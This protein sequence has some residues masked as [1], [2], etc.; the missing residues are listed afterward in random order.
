MPHWQHISQTSKARRDSDM[1]SRSHYHEHS[2]ARWEFI[3]FRSA[4]EPTLSRWRW[5]CCRGR[6]EWS[7]GRPAETSHQLA[8]QNAYRHRFL[9]RYSPRPSWGLPSRPTR[10][11][12]A[13]LSGRLPCRANMLVQCPFAAYSMLRRL[14]CTGWPS[15]R[16]RFALLIRLHAPFALFEDGS[17]ARGT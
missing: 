11:E 16:R 14:T 3:G 10:L 13:K 1:T 17:V 8:N 2:R 5:G 12:Y 15:W 9:G 4:R 7:L 6:L